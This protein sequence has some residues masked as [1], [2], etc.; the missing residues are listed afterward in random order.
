MMVLTLW[1]T[2]M[3]PELVPMM[4]GTWPP[5][6]P[7]ENSWTSVTMPAT[8]MAFWSSATWIRANSSAPP[9][10]AQALVMIRMGVRLPTN[11]ASTCCRPRG[12]A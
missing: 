4:M 9:P 8:S 12:T 3:K 2:P 1:N 6:G 7:T 5:M 10:A 11:M